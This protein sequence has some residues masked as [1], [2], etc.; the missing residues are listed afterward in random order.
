MTKDTQGSIDEA[1]PGP[2]LMNRLTEYW[3]MVNV[4]FECYVY[5]EAA[6]TMVDADVGADN[7]DGKKEETP[8]I[9]L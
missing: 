8:P 9:P 5:P 4:A 1:D 3:V 2:T 6:A 7:S